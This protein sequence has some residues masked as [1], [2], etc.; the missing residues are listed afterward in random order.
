MKIV[1]KILKKSQKVYKY[2]DVLDMSDENRQYWKN[3][4]LAKANSIAF[5][6]NE[7]EW[8]CNRILKYKQEKK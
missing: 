2:L 7:W 5:A 6:I 1:N 8:H 3:L 4:I